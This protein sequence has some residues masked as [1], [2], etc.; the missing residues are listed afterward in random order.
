MQ[1]VREQVEEFELDREDIVLLL[2]EAY[3]R[4]FGKTSLGGITRLE[5]LI[6]LLQKET[7]FQKI[8]DLYHFVPHNFG[9]FSKEIYGAV[10]FLDGCGLI[11]TRE[12]IYSS[13]YANRGEAQLLEEVDEGDSSEVSV[14][15]DVGATEKVFSLTSDGRKVAGKL[16][17]AIGKAFSASLGQLDALTLR[18]GSLPLN[19]LIR[20]VYR[21]Y[22]ETT[23]KSIHPEARRL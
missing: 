1:S 19:Q 17:E 16:R 22:P 4:L 8:G 21:R 10:E 5:K 13:R 11:D 20:Y 9:P 2:L 12:R 6:Y 3:E 23:G 18:Y 15:D 7:D 14:G